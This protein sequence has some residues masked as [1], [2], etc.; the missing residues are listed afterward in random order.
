MIEIGGNLLAAVIVVAVA[1]AVCV[2]EWI[3]HR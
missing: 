1:T 2:T 3:K